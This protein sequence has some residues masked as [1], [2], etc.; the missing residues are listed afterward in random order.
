[1]LWRRHGSGYRAKNHWKRWINT[2]AGTVKSVDIIKFTYG[3]LVSIPGLQDT[4]TYRRGWERILGC[5]ADAVVIV[6]S[7]SVHHQRII[8]ERQRLW[9][10]ALGGV[11][12]LVFDPY[13]SYIVSQHHSGGL[14]PR[15]VHFCLFHTPIWRLRLCISSVLSILPYHLLLLHVHYYRL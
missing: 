15:F 9:H 10:L 14:V 2:R 12:F 13:I 4:T 1:M 6:S 7:S 11:F 8:H 3:V 5:I